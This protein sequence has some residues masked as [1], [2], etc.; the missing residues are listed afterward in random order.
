[1][2]N[3]SQIPQ[4]Q[5][6]N[7]DFQIPQQ[8]QMDYGM[9]QQQ[10]MPQQQ[11][12]YGMAQQLQ[13]DYSM[14]QQLITDP[15]LIYQ[16]PPQQGPCFP[17]PIP[18]LSH[19]P[20]SSPLPLR[21]P[22][23]GYSKEKDVCAVILTVN[24]G[25]SYDTL[26]RSVEQVPPEDDVA[27]SLWE[28]RTNHIPQLEKMIKGEKIE[29]KEGDKTESLLKEILSD[30]ERAEPQSVL[31]NFECCSAF[32]D[33]K[34]PDIGA[35]MRTIRL[36]LDRGHN[37][38][39]GDF[40]SKALITVWDETIMGPNPF[41]RCGECSRTLMLNF[42]KKTL[43]E[44]PSSQLQQVAKLSDRGEA[45]LSAMG[46]TCLFSV[47]HAKSDTTE[48]TIEVLTVVSSVDNDRDVLNTSCEVDADGIGLKKGCAGHVLLT[49]PNG[50]HL[51]V[52][53]GHWIELSKLDTDVE[54]VAATMASKFGEEKAKEFQE[55]YYG[56]SGAQQQQYLQMNAAQCVQSSA[57]VM[58]GNM[59]KC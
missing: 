35:M 25:G 11:M 47:D 29:S 31:L 55:N 13:M 27:I 22:T 2:N 50:G 45:R 30:L 59:K 34:C 44:C 15:N 9:P 4:Q 37:V 32:G 49:Y 24:E 40:S 56:Y 19:F 23:K 1:M 5:Q 42:S 20:S 43:Q 6:M 8:Q 38:N 21:L 54:V 46:G 53:S 28:L 26:F 39:T 41:V 33:H 18:E 12:S 58:Y 36:F 48:Y 52:S 10:Q 17:M 57:P 14:P 51:V 3:D 16:I 7:N